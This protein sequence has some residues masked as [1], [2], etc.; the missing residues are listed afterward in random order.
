MCAVGALTCI[1]I[2]IVMLWIDLVALSLQGA[3][4][5]T[6]IFGLVGPVVFASFGFAY[7][8]SA[9]RGLPLEGQTYLLVGNLVSIFGNLVIMIAWAIFWAIVFPTTLL[10]SV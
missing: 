6:L 3:F 7:G 5:G 9:R 8:L 2:W 10:G 1:C 4:V